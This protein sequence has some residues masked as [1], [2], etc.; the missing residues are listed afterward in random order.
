MPLEVTRAPRHERFACRHERMCMRLGRTIDEGLPFT[1]RL[2]EGGAMREVTGQMLS[3]GQ[4]RRDI[5]GSQVLAPPALTEFCSRFT[6]HWEQCGPHAALR[7]LNARTRFRYT[8]I[9]AIDPPTLRSID[10]FDRE[11]PSLHNLWEERPT[12][13]EGNWHVAVAIMHA[14][15]R[16]GMLCHFDSRPRVPPAGERL[17][18]RHA[19]E[20][21]SAYVQSHSP[22]AN[23]VR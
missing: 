5:V 12:G 6:D 17:V 15:V 8:G 20:L 1:F 21:I 11:N 4:T 13:A 2:A 10:L 3:V 23:S 16:V 18:L 19:A 14:R 22:R 9:Y 7:F